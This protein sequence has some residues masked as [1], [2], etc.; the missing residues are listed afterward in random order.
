MS[1]QPE[2]VGPSAVRLRKAANEL[3]C[4]WPDGGETR[5]AGQA[6]RNACRCADCVSIA[7]IGTLLDQPETAFRIASVAGVGG[8]GIQIVFQDGHDRGIYPWGYLR[9]LAIG[10]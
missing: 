2:C 4:I 8:Y 3:V 10:D 6:L 1:G 7:A 5:H 9:E